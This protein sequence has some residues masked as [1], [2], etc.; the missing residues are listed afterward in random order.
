M[1]RGAFLAKLW[2]LLGPASVRQGGFEY[3][4]RDCETGLEL[5]AYCGMHGPSYGGDIDRRG[6]LLRVLE[7]FEQ[8]LDD[9][10]AIECAVTYTAEA[11]Y[12]G[13]MRVLGWKDGR[14]FDVEDRRDRKPA[15]E[16]RAPRARL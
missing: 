14:S 9:T 13:G 11:D 12:G 10:P 4:V 1:D 5:I 2:A 7:A 6:E 8:V 15:V 3:C 16:R